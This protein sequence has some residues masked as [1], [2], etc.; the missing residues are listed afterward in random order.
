MIGIFDSGAGG[1][2]AIK[3]LRKIAPNVNICFYADRKNAPY[4]TKGCEELIGFIH[5][6]VEKLVAFGAERILMACCTASALYRYLSEEEKRICIPIIE[7]AAKRALEISKTKRIG[8]IAT[9]R[10]VKESAFKKAL[11]KLDYKASVFELEAQS[12]VTLVEGGARDFNLSESD[13]A[14]VEET[15]LPLKQS[16][17]DTLILGC[18]HF[19]HISR[20]IERVLGVKTVN[21]SLEGALEVAK[22][23]NLLENGR[24]VYL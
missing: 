12:F 6:N 9:E 24:T 8:V 17:I 5:S 16:G 11:L 20:E 22:L 13:K 7:P 10:T 14:S 23:A 2:T 18:T 21:P 19:P 4:G 1:L 15:L 3:E